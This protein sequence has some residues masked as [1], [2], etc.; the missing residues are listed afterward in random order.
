MPL[1]SLLLVAVYLFLPF[2]SHHLEVD[3][4]VYVHLV[5]DPYALQLHSIQP[6]AVQI[7]A[8]IVTRIKQIFTVSN[9]MLFKCMHTKGMSKAL[10]GL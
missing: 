3:T 6:L 10:F 7:P 2:Q 1:L 9:L 8:K 4:I 5:H